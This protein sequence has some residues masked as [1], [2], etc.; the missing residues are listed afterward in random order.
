MNETN[1]REREKI[2]ENA[3]QFYSHIRPPEMAYTKE[4]DSENVSVFYVFSVFERA[5][6][7]NKRLEHNTY[8]HKYQEKNCIL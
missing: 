7:R 4:H 6:A 3:V 2:Y 1:E 5:I 8:T